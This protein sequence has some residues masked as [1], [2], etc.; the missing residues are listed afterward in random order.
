MNRLQDYVGI[1]SDELIHRIYQKT[2]QLYNK[3]IV[4]INSTSQGGGVAEILNSLVPLMNDIGLDAGWRVLHGNPDFFN[5]TKKFHNALQGDTINLTNIKKEIYLNANEN[6]SKFT[7]LEHECIIVHDPQPLPLSNF[8]QKK[9]P[10]VWR[11]HIDLS[12]PNRSL[13]SF[14][15]RYILKYDIVIV[16]HENYKKDDLPVH[17]RVIYPAINPL[18]TKN[19]DISDRDVNKYLQKFNIPRDKPLITQISRFDKWKDPL[20]VLDVF[21]KVKTKVDARLVLC[22]SM[23]SDDPEGIQI[24]EKVKKKAGDLVQKGDVILITAENNVLVNA[25]QRTSDVI[26]QKSVREGFGLTVTEALW[27][28][29]PVVA[30]DK[31]GIPL[32]VKDGKNGYTLDPTDNDG[33]ADRIIY[34]LENPSVGEEFGKNG[35]EHVRNNFLITRLLL[36]YLNLLE[37]LI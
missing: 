13:W 17:Q 7:H 33:F 22:G 21:K 4:H 14:L 19:M 26:V 28:G 29:T 12:K 32:Q 27:K 2:R 16:S 15:K 6:F 34:L 1:I 10:W 36:D 23:A 25:L 3:H 24:F 11:C 20:G 37:E 8:Y 5:I 9:Q 30:S 31:G 18:T 35:R